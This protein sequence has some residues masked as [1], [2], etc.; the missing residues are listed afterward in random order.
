MS[1]VYFYLEIKKSKCDAT[2]SFKTGFTESSTHLH[3][4]FISA[5]KMECNACGTHLALY[6]ARS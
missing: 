6:T 4:L 2:H 5:K 1:K 3:Y